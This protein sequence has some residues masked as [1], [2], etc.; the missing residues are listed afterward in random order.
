MFVHV[1]A[2]RSEQPGRHQSVF[3]NLCHYVFIKED[4][5]NMLCKELLIA[6]EVA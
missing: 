1:T 6:T 3:W 2:N 5:L 4:E